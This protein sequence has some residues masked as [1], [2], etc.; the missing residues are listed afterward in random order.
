VI[1]YQASL[2]IITIYIAVG[3]T[4]GA[5]HYI[6]IT[7]ANPADASTVTN[8]K[9]VSDMYALQRFIE[10]SQARKPG[11]PIKFNGMLYG[12]RCAFFDMILHSMMLLDHPM[13]VRFKQTCVWPIRSIS[14]VK[15]PLT[16]T[17]A[18]I[19]CVATLKA[20]RPPNQDQNAWGGLN[21]WQ[22][23]RLHSTRVSPE[24]CSFPC[25]LDL[26]FCLG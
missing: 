26:R 17:V 7:A 20:A 23:L 22:N 12:A 24:F 16:L 14:G 5:N 4:G 2:T 8:T 13:H 10:I 1:Q 11:F 15:L 19:N 21:W 25:C 3:N 6:E 18:T 9:I